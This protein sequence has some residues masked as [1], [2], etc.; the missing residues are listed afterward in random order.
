MI[1]NR[2]R[3]GDDLAQ[4]SK[5]LA[6]QIG[7]LNRQAGDVA[8]RSRQAR[9]EAAADRIAAVAKTIGIDRGRLLCCEHRGRC[10]A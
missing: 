8:A 9:D 1:A 3:R 5:P 10:C 7:S 4:E 2:R 6:S